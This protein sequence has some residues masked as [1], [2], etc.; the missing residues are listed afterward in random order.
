MD[1]YNIYQATCIHVT[2]L[3]HAE[4]Y[5]VFSDRGAVIAPAIK[6]AAKPL[7]ARDV[8]YAAAR[9]NISVF[10]KPFQSNDQSTHMRP[11]TCRGVPA[12]PYS[13]YLK[14]FVSSLCPLLLHG[15]KFSLTGSL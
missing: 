8:Y 12:I 9:Q 14:E 7:Q 13:T 1:A 15:R 4:I 6:P 5:R 10:P 11:D 2:V 3:R